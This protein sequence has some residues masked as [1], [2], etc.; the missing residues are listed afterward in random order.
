[1]AGLWDLNLI[2]FFDFYLALT[3]LISIG[4]RLRQYVNM[5]R[6]VR[7]VPE[8]WPRLFQLVK[9]HHG[10][11]LTWANVAPAVLALGL[12]LLQLLASRLLWPHANLTIGQ[13]VGLWAAVPVVGLL[14]TAM[15]GVDVYA[16]VNV[17]EVDRTQLEGY[18]DQAEYWLKSWTAPVVRILTL[19][20]INPRQMVTVEVRKALVDASQMLNSTLWWVC[21]QTGL[22]IAFG[23]AL[24]LTFAFNLV[25]GEW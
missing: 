10:I 24:W 18:F 1:M 15:V 2:R 14:G 4:L 7:A 17:G 16:T 13:L 6:L 19:G 25:S 20:Y 5:I 22:R 11:F 9:Q 12:M 3:F 23:L 8:R 21:V